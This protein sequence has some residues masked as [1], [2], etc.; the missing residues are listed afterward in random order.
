M[1][2]SIGIVVQPGKN[3]RQIY[4]QQR[5]QNCHNSQNCQTAVYA[6]VLFAEHIPE[7]EVHRIYQP[8]CQRP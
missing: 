5:Y 3:L 1:P 7:V 6:Y 8:R 2:V 4:P